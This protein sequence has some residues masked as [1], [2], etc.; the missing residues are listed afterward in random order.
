MLYQSFLTQQ[1]K[2]MKDSGA[3]ISGRTILADFYQS[4]ELNKMLSKFNAG[5]GQDD[6]KSE[7]FAVLCEKPENTIIDLWSKKQLMFFATGV[8]QRMIFQKGNRF[9]RRY[10]MQVYEYNEAIYEE[11]ND[12]SRIEREKQLQELEGAIEK[13]LHWVER[14]MIK[15]HQEL[16]SMEKIS[17]E[18]KISMKQVDRIYKKGKEK[19]RTA[20]TGKM[21]GNYLLVSNEMLIDVPE[22]VTPDNINDILE[23]V[24][25]YMMQRLHGRI[26]PSKSKKNG[27]IKEIQPIRVKKVI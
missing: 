10:R 22:D 15:L 19:I 26:I 1:S 25:E 2:P 4:A 8:V 5:G 9:H 11:P 21:I 14:A 23:E 6:L 7:L 18:T 16:G 3:S 12:E 20:M 17:K 13:D 24:H 27:Y